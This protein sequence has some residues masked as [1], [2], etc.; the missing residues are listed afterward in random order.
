L[1]RCRS[2]RSRQASGASLQSCCSVR[3]S[4]VP[5]G[6]AFDISLAF[7]GRFDQ[8][9]DGR[10]CSA[11]PG[12]DEGCAYEHESDDERALMRSM[13]KMSFSGWIIETP[14]RHFGRAYAMMSVERSLRNSSARPASWHRWHFVMTGFFQII[15]FPRTQC[16][17]D[18]S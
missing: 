11:R 3:F 1:D 5:E 4:S 10:R 2:S 17:S 6:G 13:G 16:P 14:R 12:D 18:W 9:V 8:L 7:P 15:N